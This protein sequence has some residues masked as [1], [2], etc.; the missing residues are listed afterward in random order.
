MKNQD[1]IK[2]NHKIDQDSSFIRFHPWLM[3]GGHEA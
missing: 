2:S 3:I 1:E